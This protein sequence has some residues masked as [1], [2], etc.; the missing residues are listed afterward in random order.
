MSLRSIAR[1][2]LPPAALQALRSV[3]DRFVDP[4]L[5]LVRDL[6]RDRDRPAQPRCLLAYVP[7]AWVVPPGSD[8]WWRHTNVRE[9]V[10]IVRVL[11]ARG[12]R[13]DVGHVEDRDLA[14][15]TRDAGYDLVLGLGDAF[16]DVATAAG[17]ARR[18]IYL[19]ESHP[20]FTRRREE[21]RV[22]SFSARHGRD[23]PFRRSGAYLRPEQ[24]AVADAGIALGRSTLRTYA[25]F[26]RP[27]VALDPTGLLAPGPLPPR[28]LDR[29]RAAF[30]WFGSSGA[31]LKGLDLAVDAMERLDG[32]HLHV[33]GLEP[34]ERPLFDLRPDRVTD[35]GFVD[36]RSARFAGILGQASFVVLPSC[37]EGVAT[38][39]LTCMNHG[40]IPVVTP[41][42]GIEA[43]DLGFR[44][45]G[46][47]V[48]DV[49]AALDRARR[50]PVPTLEAMH[51]RVLAHARERFVPAAFARR[52]DAALDAVLG[53]PA[54]AG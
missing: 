49:A 26:G 5:P 39:V 18:V 20:D 2:W 54:R 23:V 8:A 13:V 50:T 30:V 4:P 22:A 32:C 12:Y 24:L 25:G 9:A 53:A 17:G 14:R 28:D 41:E 45:E 37:A 40:L 33:C 3:R 31:I 52:F 10:E 29:T 46:D 1:R 16:L 43:G 15:Q 35:H 42:T 38:S 6:Y 11:G 44:I 48:A 7:T 51:A 47:H 36:V 34:A 21:E 27:L 19:T